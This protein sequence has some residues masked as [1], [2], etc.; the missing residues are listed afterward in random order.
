MIITVIA[1]RFIT[2]HD[3]IFSSIA[4][5]SL[6]FISI[7][8]LHLLSAG[9]YNTIIW[10]LFFFFAAGKSALCILGFHISLDG[11]PSV[12]SVVLSEHIGKIFRDKVP[13]A[14]GET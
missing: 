1:L 8:I 9:L 12:H 4:M 14:H 5:S 13:E 3:W 7:L 2:L 10:A 6:C 11:F